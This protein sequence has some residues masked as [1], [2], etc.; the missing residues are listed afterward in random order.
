MATSTLTAKRQSRSLAQ[1]ALR[2]FWRNPTGVTG[3]VIVL[4]FVVMS[5]LAPILRPYD[6]TVD[7]NLRLRNTP[8]TWT[9]SAEELEKKDLSQMSHPFGTD[10]QGRDILIRVWHGGRISLRVGLTAV[11]IALLTGT[12]LGLIAGYFGGI[13]DHVISWLVDILLA[14]PGILL[15]I[16]IVAA[17]GPSL[18][19][20]L[21]AISITQIPIYIRISRAMTLSLRESEHVQAAKSL[22]AKALRIISQHILPNGLSPLIVQLSLSIGTVILDVAA[23]GFLGLG[24]TPPTPEWG[25]M[26]SDGF[27]K[28]RV[29]PWLSIFPGI[30]IFFSVVGF[31]LLGDGIRDVLDPRLKSK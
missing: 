8:P 23:L 13:L 25:A 20:S 9:L 11:A 6:A 10:Q 28:F 3:L 31:N 16:A 24:A 18:Q 1:D 7:R 17:L 5:L 30:A 26:I 12:F 19:N 14:F 2:R 29:A 15:A 27:E 22:G 4:F 21:I